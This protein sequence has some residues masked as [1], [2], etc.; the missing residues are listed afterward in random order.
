MLP[1]AD[2]SSMVIYQVFIPAF[3]NMMDSEYYFFQMVSKISYF[4]SLGINTV[5]FFLVEQYSCSL[6]GPEADCWQD[7]SIEYPGI[8]N[9]FFGSTSLFRDLVLR[10]H[11][12][13]IRVLLEVNWSLFSADSILFDNDCDGSWGSF[14]RP[15]AAAQVGSRRKLDFSTLKLARG[16][17]ERVLTRWRRE[18][19]VDG[20]VW[21]D[22]GCLLYAGQRCL[23]G[24]GTVD[25]DGLFFLRE[26][27]R[28]ADYLHV[29]P[30]G[31]AESQIADFSDTLADSAFAASYDRGLWARARGLRSR[32]AALLAALEQEELRA[33]ELAELLTRVGGATRHLFCFEDRH[34]SQVPVLSPLHSR[35]AS[36]PATT[37]TPR[38]AC[39]CRPW[40][41]PWS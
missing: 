7:V 14:F 20:I 38:A 32:T 4:T 30:R 22:A 12:S 10:F 1:L 3:I 5:Q 15:G 16:Y 21:D 18:V 33:S 17:A 19:G 29:G 41:W 27:R 25:L 37:A 13:G 36:S 40:G 26:L 39:A 24:L 8:I 2:I 31:G 6:L 28:G 34:T 9:S 11:Q 23:E 35:R